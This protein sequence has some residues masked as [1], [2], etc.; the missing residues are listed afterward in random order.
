MFANVSVF[1]IDLP[2]T[3]LDVVMRVCGTRCSHHVAGVKFACYCLVFV[4]GLC[5]RS[6]QARRRQQRK[7]TCCECALHAV[8]RLALPVVLVHV[9]ERAACTFACD[10]FHERTGR[11]HVDGRRNLSIVCV[12]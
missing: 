4:R 1:S 10:C 3:D 12:C 5:V 6:A 11:L 7:Q 2:N 8:G 9:L